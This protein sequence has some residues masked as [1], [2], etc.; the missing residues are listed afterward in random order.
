MSAAALHIC[1]SS[2]APM[3]AVQMLLKAMASRDRQ[4]TSHE[5][6]SAWEE[7]SGS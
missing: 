6:L 2:A 4:A 1:G 5:R 7:R 3:E